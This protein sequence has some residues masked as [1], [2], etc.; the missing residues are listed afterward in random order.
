MQ[1]T[2]RDLKQLRPHLF[3]EPKAGYNMP[4]VVEEE[5]KWQRFCQCETTVV[6][7]KAIGTDGSY[8]KPC[9]QCG[10]KIKDEH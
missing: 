10:R 2:S 3:L 1:F 4:H 6:R 9:V 5:D 7:R 8:I